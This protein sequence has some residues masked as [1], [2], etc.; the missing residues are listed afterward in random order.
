MPGRPWHRAFCL[1]QHPR[2]QQGW[3]VKAKY[4]RPTKPKVFPLWLFKKNCCQPLIK[5]IIGS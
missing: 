5:I 3:A 2:R 4:V 1:W